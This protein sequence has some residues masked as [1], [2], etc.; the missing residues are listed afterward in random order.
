MP[1]VRSLPSFIFRLE[2]QDIQDSDDDDITGG[3][4]NGIERF[5]YAIVYLTVV[6]SSSVFYARS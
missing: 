3:S 2:D 6:K 1:K 4:I 5:S